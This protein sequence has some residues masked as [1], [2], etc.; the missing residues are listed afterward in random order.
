MILHWL[1]TFSLHT[2]LKMIDL[3]SIT[4]SNRFQPRLEPKLS[5]STVFNRTDIVNWRFFYLQMLLTVSTRWRTIASP[6]TWSNWRTTAIA[7]QE[8]GSWSAGK[9]LDSP[10]CE[11]Q[12]LLGLLLA[13]SFRQ[14]HCCCH[15]S[16]C[17]SDSG[18]MHSSPAQSENQTVK[19]LPRLSLILSC[20]TVFLLHK[21]VH[22][23]FQHI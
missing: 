10:V 11:L 1:F 21:Y 15:F 22:S 3:Q 7:P 18:Q 2:Q 12:I 19:Q 4:W 5:K 23:Y 14:D 8:Q 16:L 13:F 9:R 17:L 20:E 6:P